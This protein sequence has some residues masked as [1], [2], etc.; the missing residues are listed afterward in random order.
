MS[1]GFDVI[2]VGSGAGGAATAHKLVKRGKRV[3]LIEKGGR[4]PRDCSTISTREVFKLGRYANKTEW[5]DGRGRAFVPNGEHYNVGGKT[6][7]YGAAL[8]RFS[9]HEFRPDPLHQCLGWPFGLAELQPYYAEAEQLLHVGTFPNEPELQSV[10]DTI[11]A[12]DPSWKPASL[13]LGLK[14]EILNDPEEAKHFDGYASPMGYKGEAE[15]DLIIPI[16]DAPNFRLVIDNEVVGLIHAPGSPEVVTGV[17]CADA[18]VYTAPVVVLACG[19][20]SSP[21]LLQDYLARTGLVED[22]PCADLVGR[23]FKMH[24]NSALVVFSTGKNTDL[25][26]KTAIFT[27]EKYPHS[28][29]QCLGWLDGEILATQLPSIVP[30]LVTDTLGARALG[31]FVT[32]EDG[33]HTENRVIANPGGAPVLDYELDRIRPAKDEHEAII[34]DFSAKLL[35]CGFGGSDRWTGLAGTAHAVG[36]LVTGADPKASVVDAHG[37]VHGMQGLYVAD[38]SVLPRTSRVNPAL[39]IFAWGLRLGDHLAGASGANT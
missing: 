6:K 24:I 16:E 14:P 1:D 12:T 34:D 20:L 2:V 39:S 25:L 9:E 19:A 17:I 37:K 29:V 18:S 4:L 31:F 30:K 15:Q 26:R 27:N 10:V 5:R 8:L 28:T 7:W 11:V 38:G 22:L 35:Q 32:T 33:S 23:N 36:T 13:P 21:R 3:V